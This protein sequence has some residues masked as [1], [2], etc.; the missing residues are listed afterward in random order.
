MVSY[1][2]ALPDL[3]VGDG[4]SAFNNRAGKFMPQDDR[5]R[6]LLRDLENVGAA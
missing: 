3:E 2:H 6:R 5:R 1:N 4:F